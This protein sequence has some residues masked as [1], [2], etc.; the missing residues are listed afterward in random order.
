MK[1]QSLIYIVPSLNFFSEGYRG[2]VMHALG[3]CEGYADNGWDVTIV[4]GDSL[5]IFREDLPSSVNLYEIPE[6]KNFFRYPT[7]W[8][9]IFKTYKLL[10]SENKFSHIMIRYVVS[11]FFI[12]GAIAFTSSK[13]QVKILEVNSFAFHMLSNL[14]KRLNS[15]IAYIEVK[16]ANLFD[17]IYVVSVT[18]RDDPRIEKCKTKIVSIENGATK[19]KINFINNNTENKRLRLVYLGTLMPYWDFD[20]LIKAINCLNNINLDIIF[21]GDGPELAKLQN[22]IK[23]N[24]I[25]FYGRFARNDLGYLLNPNTDM[26]LLP[27]KTE[28]D[29]NLTGG[30]STKLFDYLSMKLPILAPSDGEINSVLT[31]KYNAILYKRCDINNFSMCVEK[32]KNDKMLRESIALNAYADFK[33]KYSWEARMSYIIEE[34]KNNVR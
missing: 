1:N 22:K 8:Y 5:K 29:M 24:N 23:Y 4:G 15:C 7:W 10:S 17:L 28:E 27:P 14:P 21:F 6:P 25:S 13:K 16:L 2:R 34:T 18:M 11:S 9:R 19:K 12:I 30:L 3:I 26:L 32:L 20:F 31:D 33:N